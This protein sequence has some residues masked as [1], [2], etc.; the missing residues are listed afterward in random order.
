[1]MTPLEQ[2]ANSTSRRPWWAIPVM[3][4]VFAILALFTY[5]LINRDRTQVMSG[6]AP[7]FTIQTFDGQSITLSELQGQPVIINFWASWCIE[8]D[9]EM[10]FLEDASQQYAGQITFLGID[11]L[12]T[13]PKAL[14]YLDRF[15]ITYPNAPD[16]GGRISN[17][18]NIKG[19][20]ETFFIAKDGTIQD[21]K[22]GPLSETEL[23]NKIRELLAE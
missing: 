12:D 10:A 8:C 17:D 4:T 22:I 7:D 15:D 21:L 18:F 16:L 19:V 13:E 2:P 20:P 5:A 11:Y 3:L 9:K 1:M 23:E 6:A 14:A